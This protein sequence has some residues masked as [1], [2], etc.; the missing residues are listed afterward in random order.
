LFLASDAS[1][2]TSGGEFTVDGG[3]LA[4]PPTPPATTSATA[5]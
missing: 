3:S 1:S 2:F 5:P 4:G